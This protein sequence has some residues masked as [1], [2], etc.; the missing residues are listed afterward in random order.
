MFVLGQLNFCWYWASVPWKMNQG[1]YTPLY[2]KH[3]KINQNRPIESTIFCQWNFGDEILRIKFWRWNLAL[4]F[5][6]CKLWRSECSIGNVAWKCQLINIFNLEFPFFYNGACSI[7]LYLQLTY[8]MNPAFCSKLF[9][10]SSKILK[11]DVNPHMG[12][13]SLSI[14][15]MH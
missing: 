12:L 5:Y 6:H 7:K 15:S 2:K 13:I 10:K 3:T 14:K 9:I 8:G 11:G 4:L 1:K